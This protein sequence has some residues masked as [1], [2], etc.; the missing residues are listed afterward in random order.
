LLRLGPK[1][2][3]QHYETVASHYAQAGASHLATKSKWK[4]FLWWPNPK[5]AIRKL[6]AALA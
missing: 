1:A 5:R 2:V 4:S 6:R 3:S